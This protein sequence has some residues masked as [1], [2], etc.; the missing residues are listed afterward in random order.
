M[1]LVSG[2][3]SA[4]YA[5]TLHSSLFTPKVSEIMKYLVVRNVQDQRSIYL[6]I[7]CFL[8]VVRVTH[9]KIKSESFVNVE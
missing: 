8:D 3:A 9:K 7:L 2:P 5:F 1:L 4:C 6:F